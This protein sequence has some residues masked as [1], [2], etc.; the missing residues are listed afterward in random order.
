M[1]CSAALLT[2]TIPRFVFSVGCGRDE[3]GLEADLFH[4]VGLRVDE[5]VLRV[6]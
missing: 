2:D 6:I 4:L 5:K 3:W 1:I